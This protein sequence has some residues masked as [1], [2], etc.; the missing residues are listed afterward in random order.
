MAT[1]SLE[2]QPEVARR[3]WSR[4]LGSA[5]RLRIAWSC[6]IRCS[7]SEGRRRRAG[8]YAPRARPRGARS[9]RALRRERDE[10]GAAVGLDRGA[11]AR[12]SASSRS[13]T[14]VAL[15]LETRSIRESSDIVTPSGRAVQRGHDVEAGQGG[16]VRRAGGRAARPR[17]RE[18]PRRRTQGR[19]RALEVATPRGS[20]TLM[21]RLPSMGMAWPLTEPAPSAAEPERGGGDLVRA[22]SGGS[23]GW[24]RGAAPRPRRGCGRSSP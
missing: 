2:L 4:S 6:S 11:A 15:P 20:T 9:G 10:D 23:A 7:A 14:P 16:V 17:M 8:R 19:S 24:R 5:R 1:R 22:R 12:P 3:S 18:T 21:S 13:T